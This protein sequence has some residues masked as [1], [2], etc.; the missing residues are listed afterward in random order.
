MISALLPL[1]WRWRECGIAFQPDVDVIVI[2]LLRPEH[3]GERLALHIARVCGKTL[4][5]DLRIELIGFGNSLVENRLK[6]LVQH[7]RRGLLVGEAQAET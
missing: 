7:P 4:G 2:E 1:R 6:R 3:S 5:N